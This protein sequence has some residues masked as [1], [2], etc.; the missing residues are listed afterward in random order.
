MTYSM[1]DDNWRRQGLFCG[2]LVFAGVLSMFFIIGLNDMS[3]DKEFWV[4]VMAYFNS[5]LGLTYLW[6]AFQKGAV[7]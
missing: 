3:S 6:T 7:E 2:C 4:H 5:A 1:Y